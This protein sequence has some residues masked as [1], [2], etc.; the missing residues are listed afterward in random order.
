MGR[1]GAGKKNRTESIAASLLDFAELVAHMLL[2]LY[3][4]LLLVIMPFYYTD[5]YYR[6]GSD[7]FYFFK[8]CSLNMGRIFLPVFLAY[9]LLKTIVSFQNRRESKARK[10]KDKNDKDRKDKD[11]QEKD[12]KE[13]DKKEKDRKEKDR[14]HRDKEYRIGLSLTDIFAL[15]YGFSLL[16]SYGCSRYREHA[17]WGAPGWYMGWNT[18]MILLAV[19]FLISRLWKG[20]QW[21]LKAALGAS[22]VVFVLGYLNRF[23]IYP[24]NMEG[25]SYLMTHLSTIGNMNWF[26]G[27]MVCL[28]FTGTALFWQGTGKGRLQKALYCLYVL[29][30]FGVL[31]VQGSASVYPA[32]AAVLVTLYALSAGQKGEM[33]NFWRIMLLLSLAASGTF[34]LR[35]CFPHAMTYTDGIMDFM[36]ATAFPFLLLG[37]SLILF[38]MFK[39]AAAGGKADTCKGGRINRIIDF[40]AGA[41]PYIVILL[42]A[43]Y[44]MLLIFNTLNPG[45]L[46]FLPQE[47][48]TFNDDWGSK[49]GATWKAGV[50]C[51]AEQD[52][53]HKFTGIGPD[54]M[55]MHI[56]FSGNAGLVESMQ[57]NFGSDFLTNAHCEWLTVLVNT[58]ILGLTG[59]G[60]MIVSGIVR[61]IKARKNSPAA[62]ACGVGILA[63]TFNNIF[64]FQQI[65]S[66]AMVYILLGM[67]EAYLRSR[68]RE[69]AAA[70]RDKA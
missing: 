62:C 40:T 66:V 63:Y 27:Y 50:T 7:K 19:Y 67:G 58:G 9:I 16:L 1:T 32:L 59:Y 64:S 14:E 3:L 15:L 41:M 25:E 60:G 28:F 35:R 34:V 12:K 49:R 44:G 24:I 29:L 17:L 10:D 22:A 39:G 11:K 56:Y 2:C 61:F 31:I 70:K 26:C 6:I 42:L 46:T 69:K 55:Y 57:K 13:K 43:F 38:L 8:G 47:F 23:G 33:L 30:G 20:R 68:D 51:F 48:F 65:M 21:V 54:S 4:L 53:L 37:V 45:V 5:G 52:L 36:T 18:Q